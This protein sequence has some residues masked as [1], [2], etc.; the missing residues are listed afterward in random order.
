M[1]LLAVVWGV[2]LIANMAWP[3]RE[4]YGEAWYEQYAA[5][6]F[7]AVLMGGGG[8]YYWLVQR[9]KTG[10]L[11]EHRAVSPQPTP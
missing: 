9:H 6:L 10:V 1:N 7:A 3:R 2:A 4:V 5:L 8:L 11:A